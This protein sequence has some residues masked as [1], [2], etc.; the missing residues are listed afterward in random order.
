MTRS[1]RRKV[2][3]PE[4][5]IVLLQ[6][7]LENGRLPWEKVARLSGVNRFEFDKDGFLGPDSVEVR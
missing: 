3:T 7:W 6:H 2:E 4:I 5:E 1:P